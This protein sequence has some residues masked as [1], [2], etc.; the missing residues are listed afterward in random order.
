[1]AVAQRLLT[2]EEYM[3]LPDPLDTRFELVKGEL[4]EVGFATAVHSWI[5]GTI[6]QLL[7]AFV[8]ERNL[9]YVFGDGAGYVTTRDP[10]TVR[11]PDVSFVARGRLPTPGVPDGPWPFAPDLAVEMPS[12][13]DRAGKVRAKALEYLAGGSRLVW[14]VRPSRRSVT[15]YTADGTV[16]EFGAED[17]L[18]GEDVLPG[19]RVRVADLFAEPS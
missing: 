2:A 16:R 14:I 7:F 9:G 6:Y 5:I 1:M 18:D 3:A 12:P 11:G 10:D 13:S 19:F 15:V 17:E 8:R 4:V